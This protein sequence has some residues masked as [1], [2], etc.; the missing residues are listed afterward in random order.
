[1]DEVFKTPELLATILYSFFFLF[2]PNTAGNLIQFAKL[3]L[4]SANPETTD[5]KDLDRGLISFIAIVALTGV[6]FLHYFS[7]NSGLFLN[8]FFVVFKIVLLCVTIICGGI[9]STQPENGK[10]TW[11]QQKESSD[12]LGALVYVIYSYQGWE[13]ANYVCATTSFRYPFHQC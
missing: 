9:A 12:V 5:T 1:L 8:M 10:S 6:C 13:N 2:T 3:I 11:G 7:R 4:L